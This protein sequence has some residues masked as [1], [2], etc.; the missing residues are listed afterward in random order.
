M[1]K[2]LLTGT[3]ILAILFWGG[4]QYQR[5]S[6][7]VEALER[8]QAVRQHQDSVEQ[9]LRWQITLLK[10]QDT[11]L[12]G[13]TDGA[14]KVVTRVYHNSFR[15]ETALDLGGIPAPPAGQ[16]LQIWAEK[17][18]ERQR[19]GMIP[20]TAIGSWHPVPY[21]EGVTAFFIS[22]DQSPQGDT[23]PSIVLMRGRL[24]DTL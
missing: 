6:I 18:K 15:N 7:A 24:R 4:W 10:D 21:Q 2:Q 1:N 13:L 3:F 22:Q 9:G 20:Q 16:Y 8:L 19:L 14:D 5:A 12:V 17:G 11:E 23:F